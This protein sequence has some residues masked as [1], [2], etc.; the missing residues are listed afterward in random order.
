MRL[1]EPIRIKQRL[2]LRFHNA[3]GRVGD[4][5]LGFHQLG[6]QSLDLCPAF[7]RV[8]CFDSRFPFLGLFNDCGFALRN[9]NS[10]HR[11]YSFVK[12]RARAVAAE[13]MARYMVLDN[14]RNNWL[15]LGFEDADLAGRGS[16]RFLDAMVAWGSETDIE[17]RL[18]AHFDAGADHVA[19]QP[20]DPA[21]GPAP[22][23]AALRA[24]APAG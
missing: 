20:F 9:N 23:M 3:L 7:V 2:R 12:C 11:L 4:C 22:D 5:I 15:R 17:R 6:P 10:S 13:Q 21:G 18:Q 14:Y 1:G 24:F 8:H 16:D 19:I